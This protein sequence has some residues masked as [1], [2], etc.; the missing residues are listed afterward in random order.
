[1]NLWRIIR[2]IHLRKPAVLVLMVYLSSRRNDKQQKKRTGGDK[3]PI[4]DEKIHIFFPSQ[5][6]R[7]R[8]SAKQIRQWRVNFGLSFF[9]IMLVSRSEAGRGAK[10]SF[11]Q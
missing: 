3:N 7:S 11:C 2:S 4:F 5:S 6:N 1:M 10:Y 9:S 8:Y